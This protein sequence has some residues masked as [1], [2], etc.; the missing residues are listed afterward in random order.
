MF[1]H[2]AY[3]QGP[4]SDCWL[5]VSFRNPSLINLCVKSKTR[6]K[7]QLDKLVIYIKRPQM[8][9]VVLNGACTFVFLRVLSKSTTFFQSLLEQFFFLLI[10]MQSTN[11]C[12]PGVVHTIQ[13][14]GRRTEAQGRAQKITVPGICRRYS[15]LSFAVLAIFSKG[16]KGFV[17]SRLC[18]GRVLITKMITKQ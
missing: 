5:G 11:Q 10:G 16:K 6:N 7:S 8:D 4:I 12:R 15:Q 14:E 1:S 2:N 18:R 3:N 17:Y 9:T 13:K